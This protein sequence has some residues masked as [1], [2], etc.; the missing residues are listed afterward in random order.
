M[1]LIKFLNLT[2]VE[3]KLCVLLVTVHLRASTTL[4]SSSSMK[5]IPIFQILLRHLVTL[6]F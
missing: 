3:V 1:L 2:I 6:Y 4:D 5:E